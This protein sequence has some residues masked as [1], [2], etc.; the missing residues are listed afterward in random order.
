[1]GLLLSLLLKGE[2]L[3]KDDVSSRMYY[4]LH[5]IGVKDK[6]PQSHSYL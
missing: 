1:M 6:C 5:D 4:L 3:N 2:K